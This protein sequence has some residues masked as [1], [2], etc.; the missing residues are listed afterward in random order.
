MQMSA[1][2]IY[3][4][5][6]DREGSHSYRLLPLFS[7]P[8]EFMLISICTWLYGRNPYQQRQRLLFLHPNWK[9]DCNVMGNRKDFAEKSLSG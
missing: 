5:W 9:T 1:L 2:A 7:S 3:K 8:T 6:R 4:V